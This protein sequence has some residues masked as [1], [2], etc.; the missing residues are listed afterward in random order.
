MGNT[1]IHCTVQGLSGDGPEAVKLSSA[2]MHLYLALQK[3]VPSPISG[4]DF[5][6][7]TAGFMRF[8]MYFRKTSS[9]LTQE[10]FKFVCCVRKCN[11]I[12]DFLSREEGQSLF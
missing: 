6:E 1:D 4:Q 10:K 8:F 7:I 3:A 2:T 5:W 11:I 9:I 12:L